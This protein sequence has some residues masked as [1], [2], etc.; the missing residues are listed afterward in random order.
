M[1][2]ASGV[3]APEVEIG[4]LGPFRVVVRG[5]ALDLPGA[6]LPVLLATLALAAPQ[7]VSV[8]RLAAAVW[9]EDIAVDARTNVHSNV[10]R[11]RQLLG[12]DLIVTRGA[13]YALAAAPDQVDAL[14]FVRLLDAAAAA[15]DDETERARLVDALALWRGEPLDGVRSEWL[16][17]TH[18]AR[19]QERFLAGVQRRV[20]LD[21]SAGSPAE[22]AAVLPELRELIGRHPLRESLWARL[23]VGLERDGRAAEALEQ[24]EV[25]RRHL[26]D[27]LGTDPTAELQ[28]V[29]ASLL[30]H[31]DVGGAPVRAATPA[32]MA[33]HQL[34]ADVEA[35]AGRA[36]ALAALDGVLDGA[37]P[38]ARRIVVIT[39]SAGVGKSSFALHWAHR[40]AGRFPDGQLYVNLRGFD[41]SGSPMAPAEAL[42]GFLDALQVPP[43]RIPPGPDAQAAMYR[44]LLAGTRMLVVLDNA[45]VAGQIAPLLP[46]A[47]G[48]FTVVT[49]RNQL[50]GL[51]ASTGALPVALDVL[52]TGEAEQLLVNRLGRD[53]VAAEPEAVAELVARC[54]ALP[55][56]LAVVAARAASH[57]TFRLAEL[58]GELRESRAALDGFDTGDTATDARTVFSWSYNSL[59]EP[60]AQLF[61]QLAVHPGP[62]IALPAAAGLAG[63]EP[64]D[65]RAVLTRLTRAH[66]LAEHVPGRYTFHDLLRS[67]AR[68]LAHTHDSAAERHATTHRTLDH[69][70]HSAHGADLLLYAH[71]ETTTLADARPGVTPERF[72]DHEGARAW[73]IAEHGV[74]LRTIRLAAESGFHSH[75][76]QLADAMS[77]ALHR[78][79]R[80]H[81]RIATQHAALEAARHVRDVVAESGA[82]RELG[83]ASADVGR[84][85]D[86][87][88]HLDRALALAE[89]TGDPGRQAWV[90]HYRDLVLGMQGR[91]GAALDAARAALHLFE[92]ADDRSGQAIAMSD[93]GWYQGRLGDHAEAVRTCERAL[94]EH[95]ALG[96]RSYEA[97]TWSCLGDTHH[98]RGDTTIAIDSYEHALALFHEV[99]DRYGQATT[100]ARLGDLHESNGDPGRASELRARAGAILGELDPLAAAQLSMEEH[101]S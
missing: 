64:V 35:F 9:G 37:G 34:P 26:A 70:L 13:G 96:N 89:D 7:P 60:A 65:V 5:H 57:P 20:D 99:G 45:R 53:R 78:Q 12:A 76:W 38:A 91:D 3:V 82:H 22:V 41:P 87:H 63:K 1:D 18:A 71:R 6:R 14:R 8:E 62:D 86:A 56:A 21:L 4:L 2:G 54:S 52:G 93:V 67:Y 101:R 16:E 50:P 15:T 51:L 48:C 27:E 55:L 95:R 42:R 59:D 11:L 85:D 10:R 75:V 79:G 31:R 58:A 77:V 30:A 74:L 40:V 49:S 43:Q 98:Q 90:H 47:S 25:L 36:E 83:F 44:S 97:H 100:L 61:R 72:A 69:Y 73:F 80:W 32:G 28:Q 29:H 33:P 23:L 17:R 66:L 19:L 81:D 46:G 84:F 24:Y 88:V 92:A 39:G 94:V 68:E